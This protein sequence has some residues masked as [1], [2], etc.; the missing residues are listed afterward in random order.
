MRVTGL[1]LV[2]DTM[3]RSFSEAEYRIVGA[4]TCELQWLL[5]L[6]KDLKITC[7]KLSV[8]YCDNQSALYI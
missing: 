5:Y 8:L 1:N 3:S 6:L 4:A 2:S 7:T